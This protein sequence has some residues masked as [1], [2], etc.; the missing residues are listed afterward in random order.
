MQDRYH[1]S[2]ESGVANIKAMIEPNDNKITLN[3]TQNLII[4][5]LY[6]AIEKIGGDVELLSIVGSIG[7]TLP[8]QQILYYLNAWHEGNNGFTDQYGL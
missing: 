5:K 1:I 8:D 2:I 3:N 7:D 4:Y 6:R